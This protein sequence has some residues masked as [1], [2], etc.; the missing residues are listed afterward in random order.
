MARPGL[1][2]KKKNP[3]ATELSQLKEEFRRVSEKF[4]SRE[5]ELAEAVEQQTATG[6]ILRV[7]SSSPTDIQ[8]VQDSVAENAARLCDASNA[9]IYRVVGD[10]LQVV[11]KAWSIPPPTIRLPISRGHVF[12][13]S[14]PGLH[15]PL[16]T[17][18]PHRYGRWCMTRSQTGAANPCLYD[19]FIR[20]TLP[21]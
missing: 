12:R 18:H 19:S 13:S 2:K 17:L 10:G 20:Y 1:T 15:V 9:L 8:P 21:V 6:D 14:T 5:R 11:A 7:I 16:A 4:E 3:R